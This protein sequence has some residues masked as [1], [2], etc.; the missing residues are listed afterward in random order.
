[1]SVGGAN[2]RTVASGLVGPV[3]SVTVL[4]LC[5]R[6]CLKKKKREVESGSQPLVLGNLLNN[7]T[8]HARSADV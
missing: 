6:I 4:L 2:T 1:M 5:L 8:L 3:C 7:H